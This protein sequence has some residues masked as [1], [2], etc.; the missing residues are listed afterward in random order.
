MISKRVF[1]LLLAFPLAAGAEALPV[2][3]KTILEYP[4]PGAAQTHE[5]VA[6]NNEQT[7]LIS[8]L[9]SSTLV[10][11]SRDPESGLPTG[12][13]RFP[14]GGANSGLHG[15]RAS[16]AY[17]G[18]I[19][20]TLQFDS[21]LLLIDPK[22]DDPNAKPEIVKAIDVPAPGRGPHVI[23]EYGDDLWVTLK[24][25]NYVLRI[26]HKNPKN[27]A[28]Y[29]SS[30]KPIFV[31]KHASG[32][33]YASQ[34]QSSKILRIDPKTGKTDEYDVPESKGGIPVG[35]IDG[36][37]GNV[38]FV[39]AGPASGGTGT[40]GKIDQQ[41]N[42][43]WFH[44]N[45]VL[46]VNAG[47]LHLAFD[48]APKNQPAR[49]FLLGSSIVN[50]NFPD[51]VFTVTFDKN[52]TAIDSQSSTILPT[53]QNWA[54]RIMVAEGSLFVTELKTS[55]LVQISTLPVAETPVD[56]DADFYATFG[57]GVN[58]DSVHYGKPFVKAR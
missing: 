21:K 1:L 16:E 3:P 42:I 7:L 28:L 10:K 26:N 48:K 13:V 12:A 47:L 23:T 58:T 51:A 5:L 2:Q 54:H 14:I 46:G 15:L 39:L 27:Y 35:L 53:Q 18:K 31:A 57:L 25:S 20:A 41:N 44:L 29:P 19:W 55:A 33:V 22:A 50:N 24:D 11:V 45:T 4:L 52:Y 8:Q 34:D 56:E 49:L 32:F 6:V 43:T 38:W 9:T 40:F 17:P 30:R 36:P 37:D